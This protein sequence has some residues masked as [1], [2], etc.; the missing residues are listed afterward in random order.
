MIISVDDKK[1]RRNGKFTRKLTLPLA[2]RRRIFSLKKGK[3]LY[4]RLEKKKS[5]KRSFGKPHNHPGAHDDQG[6]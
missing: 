3:N 2:S 4:D 1:K 6:C 5:K